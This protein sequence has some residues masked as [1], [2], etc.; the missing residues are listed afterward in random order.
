MAADNPFNGDRAYAMS[1]DTQLPCI[2][3]M[4]DDSTEK[5]IDGNHR[6]Y[7]MKT[8]SH[9]KAP[10]F[11]LPKEYLTKFIVDYDA[12]VYAAVVREYSAREKELER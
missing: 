8:L 1:T 3:V 12:A 5:L 9:E 6:L 2:L 4:L 10:C 11:I 7:N